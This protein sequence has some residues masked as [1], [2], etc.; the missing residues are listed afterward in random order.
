MDGAVFVSSMTPNNRDRDDQRTTPLVRVRM[1]CL[2][3]AGVPFRQPPAGIVVRNYQPGD[4]ANWL[5]IQADAEPYHAITHEMFVSRFG[6]DK[7]I[8][9]DRQLYACSP[10]GVAVGTVTAW[11]DNDYYGEAWGRLHWLAV[12][13]AFQSRGVGQMLASQACWRLLALGH[14]RAY[15]AT[16]TVRIRAIRIYLGLGF[17]PDIRTEADRKAWALVREAGLDVP[18]P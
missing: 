5:R 13:K 16:H 8:L 14:W 15:L 2:D 6:S 18:L 11:F 10:A 7:S 1:V 12:M 17:S 4:E 3:L 9:R